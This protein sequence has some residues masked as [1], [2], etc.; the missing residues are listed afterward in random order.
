MDKP[1][2]PQICVERSL[3]SNAAEALQLI[4]KLEDLP[5]RDRYLIQAFGRLS[6]ENPGEAVRWFDEQ[7]KT[8]EPVTQSPEM[9]ESMM[10]AEARYDPAIRHCLLHSGARMR[11]RV[12]SHLPRS[13]SN[14]SRALPVRCADGRLKRRPP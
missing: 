4:L 13:A 3:E 5:E 2:I 6:V 9:L 12:L 11:K 14:I 7:F 10:L 1:V 8:G